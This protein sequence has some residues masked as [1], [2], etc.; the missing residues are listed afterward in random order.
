MKICFLGAGALGSAIGGALAEGGADVTLVDAWQAHVDAINRGGLKLRESGVDRTVRVRAVS[1]AA[2]VGPVDLVIV[3]VKSYHTRDAIERA[4]ALLGPQTMVMSLQNGMGHEDILG[5]VVGRERVLGGKTYLGGV[6]LAPGHVIAG[7]KG[8]ETIVGELD[9]P[10]SDRVHR[11]AAAFNQAGLTTLVS[12]NIRGTI[13]D[14]LLINVAT[15]ALAGITRLTYGALYRV[16]EV[17]ACALAAI[18]EG[19]AVAK[20]EGV[21]LSYVDPEGPWIKAAEGLPAE[22]KTSMLQSLEKG[23]KTEIDFING[24]VVR[25]G[26]RCGIPTPVNQALVA[27]IKGIEAGMEQAAAAPAAKAA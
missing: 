11:V 25:G 1:D 10:R 16:P 21:A 17:K 12:D 8:K 24:A 2:A 7:L 22:F 3:L 9:G 4:A 26:A 6:L 14:K 20:A 18:A 23:T 27:C 13:W 15:G 19:I 5:E